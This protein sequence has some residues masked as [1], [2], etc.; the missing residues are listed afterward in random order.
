MQSKEALDGMRTISPMNFLAPGS[1]E[2][3]KG[4]VVVKYTFGTFMRFAFAGALCCSVTH[5]GVVPIDVVKT[6]MQVEP[7]KYKSMVEAFRRIP[8]EDGAAMLLKGAGPTA[9]G[10]FL[11]GAFK[12]GFNEFFKG[13]FTEFAGA[14]KGKKYRL[15]IWLGASACA[16][17][18]ADLFLCPLE[19]TRIRLVSQPTF[20][21]G[22]LDASAKIFRQ[23][24]FLA[25]YTGLAPL[26]LKQVPYTMAKF[27]VFEATSEAVYKSLPYKKEEMSTQAKLTVSLSSGVV[28]GIAAALISQPADTVLSR[29]NKEKTSDSFFK[30]VAR[31]CKQ[32]GVRGLFLGTGARCV[33]VGT[34]TAGQFFIYDYCKI[35][36]GVSP[37]QLYEKALKEQQG[38]QGQT[39]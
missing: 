6:K 2:P 21:R 23:E 27:S 20:G 18:I 38:Q 26:L 9:V 37:Q 19:A 7:E 33:M 17:F 12:F 25:F 30:A 35:L 8:K 15:P 36:M 10:Y 39:Q 22:L 4:G 3:P 24:G 29:V 31:I 34:I 11:Q 1:E 28:A 5:T 14:E 16:E 13:K 32:L